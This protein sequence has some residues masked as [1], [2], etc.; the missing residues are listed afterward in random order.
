[1]GIQWNRDKTFGDLGVLDL[2]EI[3]FAVKRIYWITNFVPGTIRGH[4]A[5]RTLRQAFLVLRGSVIFQISEGRKY[6]EVQLNEE[7][8]VLVIPPASWRT[9]SSNNQDSV[10]LVICDQTYEK[11]DY[12]RNWEEYLEWYDKKNGN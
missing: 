9:F 11:S 3:P 4:H 1:M 7:S 10:L 5:H 12:I 6:F 8:D 2:S